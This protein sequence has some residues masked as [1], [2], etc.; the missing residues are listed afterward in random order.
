MKPRAFFVVTKFTN[1]KG[2]TSYRVTGT[3]RD[4]ER[5]RENYPTL[6][7]A[8][9][10]KQ[11]LETE[12]LNFITASKL[13]TTR[14]TD[15]QIADA[16]SAYHALEQRPVTLTQA[17]RFFIDNYRE[18]E[19]KITLKAALE[20]FL[21]DKIAE[22]ARPHTVKNLRWRIGAFVK[23]H[24]LERLVS[25]ILPVHISEFIN[26]TGFKSRGLR[27][28]RND[29]LALS[30]F[31]SWA[32]QNAPCL[33]VNN[34]M[35]K[36]RRIKIDQADP[37]IM[38]LET[39]RRLLDA[40]RCYKQGKTLPYFTLGLFC[41]LRPHELSR[42]TW[43]N[44]DLED[45]VVTL[46][47]TIAKTRSKRHVEIADNA[48]EWLRPHAAKNI[49]IGRYDFIAVRQ[50]AQL[51]KWPVDVMRHTSISNHLT[52]H[53]HEGK[54]ALWAGNSPGII[55]RFYKGLVKINEARLFWDIRPKTQ[56]YDCEKE[57]RVCRS[58]L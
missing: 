18:P 57:Q 35:P 10:R 17:V 32:S 48:V 42:I 2:S 1:P 49:A 50:L 36:P 38:P 3:K 45:K 47:P 44:I 8:T 25:D 5:I 26:R 6:E 39:V 30:S 4:S 58:K 54:T 46:G 31:F 20:K 55:Q 43:S 51:K 16:E 24:P 14:L 56:F 21:A 9:G 19:V 22:K 29:H 37:E 28:K 23:L 13:K 53:Q 41:G 15:E 34:P 27:T 11:A 12:A 7:E 33:C 40:A 52:L